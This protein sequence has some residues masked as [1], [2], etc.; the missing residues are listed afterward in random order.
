MGWFPWRPGRQ[1]G[2][3]DRLKLFSFSRPVQFDAYLLRYKPGFEC[4]PHRDPVPGFR[5]WRLNVVLRAAR[6]GGRFYF[7][8]LHLAGF[9]GPIFDTSRVVRFRSDLEPHGV[10]RV[11]R[12]RRLVLTFGLA[13]PNRRRTLADDIVATMRIGQ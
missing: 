11:S 7:Q 3:Y 13:L 2:G 12:G 8:P 5:H 10:E 1:G 9:A 6:E 4:P